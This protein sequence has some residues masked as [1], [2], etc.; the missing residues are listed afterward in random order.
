MVKNNLEA[1]FNEIS[2][3]RGYIYNLNAM[4]AICLLI[5]SSGLSIFSGYFQNEKNKETCFDRN[6]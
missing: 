1:I 4:R 5:T 2:L 6:F 3:K